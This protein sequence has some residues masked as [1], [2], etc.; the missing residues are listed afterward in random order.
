MN[1][2]IFT[3]MSLI[4]VSSVGFAKEVNYDSTLI[5]YSFDKVEKFEN[6]S[7]PKNFKRDS[8]F[9]WEFFTTAKLNNPINPKFVFELN[10]GSDS[11]EPIYIKKIYFVA[12][13]DV[14]ELDDIINHSN[15][16]QGAEKKAIIIPNSDID[17]FISLKDKKEVF[18]RAKGNRE[19]RDSE[20]LNQEEKESISE[21]AR[22][23]KEKY[24]T[25]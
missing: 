19:R 22:V 23:Y 13:N 3:L 5:N 18:F 2:K 4:L 1:K 10:Y 11:T 9:F 14:L 20:L 17:F 24:L 16:W 6:Y 25:K 12:D 8:W 7:F 21:L 15:I